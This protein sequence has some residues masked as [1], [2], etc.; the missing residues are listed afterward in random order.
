M[1]ANL[2]IFIVLLMVMVSLNCDERVG[3]NRIKPD[4][5]VTVDKMIR[6]ESR[7][8]AVCDWQTTPQGLLTSYADYFQCY[9]QTPVSAQRG[10][11]GGTY[12]IYRV[13]DQEGNSEV[14]F[15]YIDG[16]GNVA[17]SSG[18]GME[19]CYCDAEVDQVSGDVFGCWHV[20]SGDGITTD[21]V[22]TYDL[23]H[24][25]GTAGL[26]KDP[27]ITVIDSDEMDSLDPTPNDEFIWPELKIGASPVTGSQ[28]IY[29][30]AS[31]QN[32]SDGATGYPSENVMVCYADFI[33]D[34]LSNQS[35]L[36]WNYT[37][38]GAMD[39]WNAESP[40]WYR[41]FKSWTVIDNMIIFMGYVVPLDEIEE[42][43][44]MFCFINNNYGEGD[45]EEYY[46]DW[47]F[48]EENPGYYNSAT[49]ETNYLY[50]NL[51]YSPQIPYPSVR[52]EIIHSGYFNLIAVDNGTAVTWAG[53]LGVTFYDGTE[54][55]Y[56]PS[57]FQIYPKTF[58]F[59]LITHEF[60]FYDVYPKGANPGDNIPMK[61]WDL[62]EDGEIDSFDESGFPQWAQDWPV[63]HWDGNSSCHYNQYYLSSNE[64]NGWLALIWVDGT[65]AYA[66][67]ENLP[68]YEDYT[69]MPEI[70][71]CVSND[72]GQSWSD[73]LFMN[74]CES[75]EFYN[76]E[77]SGMIPCFVYPGDFI[78]DGGNGSGILELF[79]L[80]DND[81]GSYHCLEQGLN[82]GAT[83]QYASL[84]IN[85]TE[86]TAGEKAVVSKTSL[87]SRNYP[88]PFNPTTNI[89]FTNQEEGPVK[90]NIY[91]LK[92]RK[93]RQLKDENMTRGKQRVV[94]NGKNENGIEV[95]SGMYIYQV[96]TPAAT[97]TKTMILMK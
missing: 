16:D 22:L 3:D 96:Q 25:M 28:R 67:H 19:G 37:T 1:K 43:V 5:S 26:W 30:V 92:G 61:P 68:G 82:N 63:F 17:T 84:W 38:I 77:L 23:Y 24:I 7:N 57:W 70:A 49:G 50:S 66:S 46:S 21:C 14:S 51:Q 62:N 13:K 60:S 27:V 32:S 64:E 52:Q 15:S 4:Y 39:A 8:Q 18:L 36:E 97:E 75:D 83:C 91:D 20:C 80:D 69:D 6:S 53:A 78:R 40:D 33:T 48:T 9:N 2:M 56:R 59:D 29:M 76:S 31:N 87:E 54:L 88:N 71:I 34:D 95:A 41:S 90:V 10:A 47:V 89:M 72:W 42:D 55:R 81:Y 73:P 79:F 12:I 86:L 58:S 35:N 11:D 44:R 85:F 93:V 65:R 45:W 74:A 94:W